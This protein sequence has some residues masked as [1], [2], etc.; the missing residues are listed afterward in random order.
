MAESSRETGSLEAS[1]VKS[2]FVCL[3]HLK[4]LRY[5]YVF[6]SDSH[7]DKLHEAVAGVLA[8]PFFSLPTEEVIMPER[9]QGHDAGSKATQRSICVL[10]RV[11]K[12]A[13]N[14]L[15]CSYAVC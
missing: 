4:L 3:C 7:L 8:D 13:S 5:R 12:M 6:P 15:I 1:V 14:K 11:F 2:K 10:C 9:Y